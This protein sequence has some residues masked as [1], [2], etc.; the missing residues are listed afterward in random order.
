MG[1]PPLPADQKK[2]V[3]IGLRVEQAIIDAIDEEARDIEKRHPGVKVQR[4]AIVRAWLQE[5]IERRS[6]A[7]KKK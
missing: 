5:A 7:R 6:K 3:H 4:A 1:R 2:G